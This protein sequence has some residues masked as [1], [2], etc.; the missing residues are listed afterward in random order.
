M[1]DH[2][3]EDHVIGA[4][5]LHRLARDD[6]SR[7]RFLKMAGG[8]AAAG[9]FATLLAACGSDEEEAKV[10][11]DIPPAARAGDFAILNYA[12]MLEYV[13]SDFYDK[14]IDSGMLSKPARE[15]AKTFGEH[16][17]E[18]AET[19]KSAIEDGGE[20]PVARPRTKFPLDSE[21]EILKLAATVENLGAAA[22]LGQAAAIKSEDVLATAL[23]IHTIEARHAAALNIATGGKPVPFGG[24]GLAKPAMM[25]AVLEM[26]K[27]FIVS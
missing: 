27:P 1:E 11:E 3:E 13:E 22:Y 14:V 23:S 17:R 9:A 18:H 2:A 6:S 15:M 19:L 20:K 24:A 7:K 16:E 4:G 5:A 26:V 12:L 25:K 21:R 10:D 8:M